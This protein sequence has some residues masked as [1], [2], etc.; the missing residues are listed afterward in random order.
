MK[1][2]GGDSRKPDWDIERFR[3]DVR[4]DTVVCSYGTK[5]EGFSVVKFASFS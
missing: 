5:I 1:R 4:E 2:E 3:D